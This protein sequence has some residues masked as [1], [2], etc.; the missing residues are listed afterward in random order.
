MS[1]FKLIPMNF[2]YFFPF[3]L[4][5]LFHIFDT[6]YCA[7]KMKNMFL[8]R[9]C[10]VVIYEHTYLLCRQTDVYLYAEVFIYN[11]LS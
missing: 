8:T 9:Q 10:Q 7:W 3:L 6:F 11:I 2:G 4:K 5:M 1:L